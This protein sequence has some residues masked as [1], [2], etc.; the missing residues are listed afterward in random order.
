MDTAAAA[1]ANIRRVLRMLRQEHDVPVPVEELAKL[2]GV[3][4]ALIYQRLAGRAR[5]YA[6]DVAVLAEYFGVDVAM[7]YGGPAALLGGDA[8]TRRHLT[9]TATWADQRRAGRYSAGSAGV[10]YGVSL[11]SAVA[12]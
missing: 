2:L 1:E 5:W 4:R 6:S 7:F 10:R 3:S 9:P 11:P 8:E 12:A